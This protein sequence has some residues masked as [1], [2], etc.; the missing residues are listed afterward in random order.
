M[1]SSRTPAHSASTAATSAVGTVHNPSLVYSP[2]LAETSYRRN[3][4]RHNRFDSDPTYVKFGPMFTPISTASTAAGPTGATSGTST[5]VAGR[6]LTMLASTAASAAYPSS[7]S[8]PEP[9]GSN[10]PIRSATPLRIT[11][12]TTTPNAS[13]NTRNGTF[14]AR[15]TSA[16]EVCR[17]AR[18]RT[19]ITAAPAS[20]AQA[21]A[22][23]AASATTKPISVSATTTNAN[24]GVGGAGSSCWG[25]GCTL[26]SPRKNTRKTT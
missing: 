6:L 14:A 15:T 8:S 3:T 1:P 18:L 2:A 26:R 12:C 25:S 17:R 10:A 16:A 22:T 11:A 20:A 7:A 4:L 23:P 9:D 13:T 24:T 19:A 5:S 21:G